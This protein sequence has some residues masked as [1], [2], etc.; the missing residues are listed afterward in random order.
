M[1]LRLIGSKQTRPMHFWIISKDRGRFDL[2]IET[3]GIILPAVERRIE[4]S[5]STN[6]CYIF[7][8]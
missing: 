5:S 6:K 1:R 2:D 3:I 7:Q 4:E 8:F